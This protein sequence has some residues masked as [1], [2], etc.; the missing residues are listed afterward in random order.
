MRWWA[1]TLV[2]GLLGTQLAGCTLLHELQPHR[3]RRLNRGPAPSLDPEFTTQ[4][5]DRP[6]AFH[7]APANALILVSTHRR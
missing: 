1:R 7:S 5:S 3:L 2:F 6:P 4:K